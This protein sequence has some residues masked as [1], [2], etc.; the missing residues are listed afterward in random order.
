VT[1]RQ[2]LES[3][4]PGLGLA[5]L[6]IQIPKMSRLLETVLLGTPCGSTLNL[7]TE[8]PWTDGPAVE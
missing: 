7:Y 6:Q 4:L 1:L 5:T 3:V 8:L 2:G